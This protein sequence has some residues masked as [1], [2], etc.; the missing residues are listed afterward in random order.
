ML[1]ILQ[2]TSAIMVFTQIKNVSRNTYD[3]LKEIT[4]GFKSFRAFAIVLYSVTK[5][6][7]IHTLYLCLYVLHFQNA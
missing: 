4:F 6:S 2:Y 5:K 3:C 7:Y 1:S